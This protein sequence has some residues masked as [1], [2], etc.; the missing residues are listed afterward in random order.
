LS[1]VTVGDWPMYQHDASNTGYSQAPFPNSL[2]QIWYKSYPDD[3]NLDIIIMFA[4]PVVSNGKLFITGDLGQNESMYGVICA[5]NQNNGS[6]IWKKE[7]PVPFWFGLQG[8]NSPA[9]YDGKIFVTLNSVF[10]LKSISKIVALDENTGEILW[11]KTFL[12]TTGYS[13][14]TVAEDKVFV[15]GHFTFFVPISFLY[16]FD[17]DNGELLWGRTV[18]GYIES[19]PVV[20]DNKVIVAPGR[21]SG[22]LIT[23][24]ALFPLTSGISRIYAF[25]IESGEKIWVKKVMGHLVQC[26]PTASN[27][28]LFVPSNNMIMNQWWI[29]KLSALDIDTGE[30]IWHHTMNQEKGAMWP[31]SIS[32]PSVGYG[33]VFVTESDGWIHA[34]EQDSGDLVWERELYPGNPNAGSTT[35][36]SP[37]IIDGKVIVGGNAHGGLHNNQLF[38]FNESTGELIRIIGLVEE[39]PSPFI[40]SNEMLFATNGWDGI[41]ALG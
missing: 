31:S 1:P 21:V 8:F 3:F 20:Y 35:F 7:I 12:G 22:M 17:V 27:G 41:F 18:R 40:V 9:V 28:I 38:M 32:T 34:W 11:E 2:N 23:N 4:S 37:V 13:S 16:V 29:C 19:T 10:T 6:L 24:F 26:S 14:V 15:V 5:L 25:N 30:K 36:A 33:K 39:S